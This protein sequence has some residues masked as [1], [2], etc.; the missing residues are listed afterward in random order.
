MTQP[1][2]LCSSSLLIQPLVFPPSSQL[3]STRHFFLIPHE[4]LCFYTCYCPKLVCI[5]ITFFFFFFLVFFQPHPAPHHF[6]SCSCY[7]YVHVLLAV[8]E[9]LTNSVRLYQPMSVLG[10]F[11]FF[12]FFF[13]ANNT[14]IFGEFFFFCSCFA[15]CWAR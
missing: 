6:G 3:F 11:F 7:F 15:V 14:V 9:R 8:L 12:L 5:Q 4:L 10:D 2:L 13:R 1:T